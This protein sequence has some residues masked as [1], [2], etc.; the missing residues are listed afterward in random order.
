MS[1]LFEL[2]AV[3]AAMDEEKLCG[4]GADLHGHA[5]GSTGHGGSPSYSK[6]FAAFLC[7]V[8]DMRKVYIIFEGKDVFYLKSDIR[9]EI[10][11]QL[12]LLLNPVNPF[13][14]LF[15]YSGADV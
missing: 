9:W 7:L 12:P 8:R 10:R 2:L 3:K 11:N 15:R 1:L 6:A 14:N 13:Q 5:G 4:L